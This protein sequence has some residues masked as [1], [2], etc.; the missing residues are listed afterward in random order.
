MVVIIFLSESKGISATRGRS[1]SSS[2]LLNPKPFAASSSAT[3]VESPKYSPPW[4]TRTSQHRAETT[5][6]RR[7]ASETDASAS[8]EIS[9]SGRDSPSEV[10]AST[11]VILLTVRVPVLS[12]HI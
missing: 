12:E 5:L 8:P 10:M 2:S 3:S 6:E 11:T 4:P 1:A 9:S 7:N